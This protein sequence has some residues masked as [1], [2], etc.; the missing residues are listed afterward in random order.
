[1]E[2]VDFHSEFKIFQAAVR[3]EF[4]Y[5][6]ISLFLRNVRVFHQLADLG[7][8]AFDIC[9]SAICPI[10][11]R[12]MEFGQ[13]GLSNRARWGNELMQHPVANLFFHLQNVQLVG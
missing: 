2:N 3:L 13:K 8:I 6:T 10:L 7:W 12:Q 1:M 9:S 5:E 11:L 4:T